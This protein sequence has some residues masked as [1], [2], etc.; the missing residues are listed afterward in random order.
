MGKG[1]KEEQLA[2]T[3]KSDYKDE[4]AKRGRDEQ[5]NETED[6]LWLRLRFFL[7]YHKLGSPVLFFPLPYMSTRPLEK[8]DPSFLRIL[9][10]SLPFQQFMHTTGYLT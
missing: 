8:E 4:W 1:G 6:P 10:V 9:P 5:F 3:I 2:V 7:L